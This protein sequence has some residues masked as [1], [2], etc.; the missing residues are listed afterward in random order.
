MPFKTTG[1]A[2]LTHADCIDGPDDCRGNMEYR[3]ALS[4]TGRS[5]P[6]C[7]HHWELRLDEQERIDRDYPD[8]DTP[9]AWFDPS[10]A[11]ESWDDE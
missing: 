1:P 11:G 3:H 10:Y 4:G 5:F 8:S 9:P 2:H 6:R 7:D